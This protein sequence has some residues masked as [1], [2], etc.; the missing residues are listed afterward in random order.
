MI[1]NTKIPLKKIHRQPI[2]VYFVKWFPNN[3]HDNN[4]CQAFSF[5]AS[6]LDFPL[7][8]RTVVTDLEKVEMLT[9]AN[10]DLILKWN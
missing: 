6:K 5:Y 3:H 4:L 9:G 10:L 1:K 8:R 2:V 7:H